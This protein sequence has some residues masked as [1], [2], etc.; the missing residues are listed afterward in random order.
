MSVNV[1]RP[2]RSNSDPSPARQTRL[3]PLSSILNNSPSE[4]GFPP[5]TT[6]QRKVTLPSIEHITSSPN[7]KRSNSFPLYASPVTPVGNRVLPP[8]PMFSQTPTTST[9]NPHQPPQQQQNHKFAVT[10]HKSGKAMFTSPPSE[11]KSFAFISHSVSTFLSSEPDIDN[12][13]LARRKRRRTSP[14]ELAILQSEFE[15]GNTP[16]KMRRLEI[17]AKVDMTEK[18]VQIWFQN[19]RQSLRKNNQNIKEVVLDIPKR[20]DLDQQLLSAANTSVEDDSA[21]SVES[22]PAISPKE[23]DLP[24][25]GVF[26]TPMKTPVRKT[27]PMSV[28]PNSS[29]MTFKFK[30]SELG[31]PTPMTQA[32][33]K[34]QKPVMRLSMNKKLGNVLKDTTNVH[35]KQNRPPSQGTGKTDIECVENLLSLRDQTRVYPLYY[36]IPMLA[37]LAFAR[38]AR[39]WSNLTPS[40]SSLSVLASHSQSPRVSQTT[41]GSHSLESLQ[42][43]SQLALHVVSKNMVVLSVNNIGLSVQK[44]SWDLVLGWVLHDGDD[45]LQLFLGQLTSSLGKVN[46]RLLA[47]QVGVSSTNTSNGGERIHDLDSSVNVG[48]EETQNVLERARFLNNKSHG[49]CVR[50]TVSDWRVGVSNSGHSASLLRSKFVSGE[51]VLTSVGRVGRSDTD[52]IEL[53][54]NGKPQDVSSDRGV[55]ECIMDGEHGVGFKRRERSQ[56]GQRVCRWD[57]PVGEQGLGRSGQTTGY[58]SKFGHKGHQQGV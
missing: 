42:V 15:K 18:A 56:R 26:M 20:H 3:P 52:V 30:A 28:T 55:E 13:R 31:L 1:S 8:P 22:S 10:P 14:A 25:K 45:S 6:P 17:A 4:P 27:A 47:H 51:L 2:T 36:L 19:K 39:L 16:N 46:V 49:D 57:S 41:V 24:P 5:G 23:E 48:V 9:I 50:S 7:Y 43:I 37:A 29:T 11:G 33:Q 38:V 21:T 35:N 12:A 34:R 54:D 53:H 32:V 58:N 40:T 44:P